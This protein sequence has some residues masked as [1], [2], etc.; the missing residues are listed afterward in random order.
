MNPCPETKETGDGSLSP[1]SEIPYLKSS[2]I[3]LRAVMDSDAAGLKELV[4]SPQVYRYLPTFLFEKKY[5]DVHT[6]IGRLYTE[7]LEDSLILG[8]FDEEGFGGSEGEKL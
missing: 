3:T 2:R 7:C 1:F 6:V 8:V 4:D 5:P